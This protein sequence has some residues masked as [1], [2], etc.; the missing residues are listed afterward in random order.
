MLYFDEK[1]SYCEE[2]G[3]FYRKGREITTR[4]DAIKYKGTS[5]KKKR[6][7][8]YLVHGE[9]PHHQVSHK[10]GDETDFRPE[11][12]C[13]TQAHN[14]EDLSGKRYGKLIVLKKLHVNEK[15]NTVWL[16][17]CDCGCTKEAVTELLNNGHIRS[18]GCAR[19]DHAE[20]RKTT[21]EWRGTP[22]YNT[23]INIKDRC[24][25]ENSKYYYLY[26]G[27]GIEVSERWR[28]SF[29]N[30][31]EDIGTRPDW[32]S[33]IERIDTNGN[34]ESKNCRWADYT[35]QSYNTRRNVRITIN[36]VTKI[37]E[38]W[39]KESPVSRSCIFSRLQRGWDEESAVFTPKTQRSNNITGFV[40]EYKGQTY[41][42]KELCKMF[43]IAH[44]T[45]LR[46]VKIGMPIEEIVERYRRD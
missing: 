2:T 25:N 15:R 26:G 7:V 46:K 34:Y 39:S 17:Q 18:C 35:E 42:T 38:E 3:K 43:D 14:V 24:Y 22:E 30:F 37:L 5:Y 20:S 11:N 16:C 23:W 27:R 33:S 32:A 9:W 10:N 13:R 21:Y 29:F 4:V 12:I 40:H 6:L 8:W 19:Y 1:L 31:L 45:F 44:C 41:K 36:G 28:Q